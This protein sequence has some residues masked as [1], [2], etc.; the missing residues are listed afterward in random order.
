MITSTT[1][2]WYYRLT[3]AEDRKR[4]EAMQKQYELELN[5]REILNNLSGGI[6]T[7]QPDVFNIGSGH[8]VRVD[9]FKGFTPNQKQE[10]LKA[11]QEQRQQHLLKTEKAKRVDQDWAIHD[12]ASQRAVELLEREKQ[13][14]SKELAIQIRKEN[15]AKALLDKKRYFK[16]D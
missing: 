16:I 2:H 8:K 3:L 11:Q 12:I 6:L 13:R 7:E 5:T 4:R 10:I 14:K 1:K 15:E 9:V